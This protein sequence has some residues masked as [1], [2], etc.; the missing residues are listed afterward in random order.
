MDVARMPEPGATE[1]PARQDL[2]RIYEQT[3]TIAVVGPSANGHKS[4]HM[5]PTYLQS[6]RY[7]I[8][9]V[10]PKGGEILGERVYPSLDEIDS[11]VDVVDVFRPRQR[12]RPS[13]DRRSRLAPMSFGSS[14]ART[15]Q[16]PSNSLPMRNLR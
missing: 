2:L 9:P 1:D 6:Y 11:L 4:A 13:R 5:I 12:P 16:K 8:I 3:K 7:R 10:N 15:P 14:L